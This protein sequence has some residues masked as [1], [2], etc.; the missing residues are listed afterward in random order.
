MKDLDGDQNEREKDME[1]LGNVNPNAFG[2]TK[3]NGAIVTLLHQDMESKDT[4][5]ASAIKSQSNKQ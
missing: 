3:S 1:I 4:L 2:L 5:N